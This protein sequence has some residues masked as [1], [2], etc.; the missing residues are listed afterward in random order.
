MRRILIMALAGVAFVT[1]A[2]QVNHYIN[3]RTY[4]K[5]MIANQKFDHKRDCEKIWRLDH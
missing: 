1:L 3:N 2:V 4:N 5:C